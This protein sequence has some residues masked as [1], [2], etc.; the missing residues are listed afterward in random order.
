MVDRWWICP[1]ELSLLLPSWDYRSVALDTEPAELVSEQGND[2]DRLQLP[3]STVRSSGRFP[4][5]IG[6]FGSL[7]GSRRQFDVCWLCV[8]H[9][10]EGRVTAM[11]NVHTQLA[12]A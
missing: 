12:R 10:I 5:V 6:T 1:E 4:A 11:K 9:I 2:N 8:S 3:N 7:L